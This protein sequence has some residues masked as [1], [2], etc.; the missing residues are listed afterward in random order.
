MT[1]GFYV[2]SVQSMF[3]LPYNLA[4]C[5]LR[6]DKAGRETVHHF[7]VGLFVFL[8]IQFMEFNL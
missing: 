3:G 7:L 2:I 1:S 4:T 5:S 6:A 8:F